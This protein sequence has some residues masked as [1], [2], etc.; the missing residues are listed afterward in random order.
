MPTDDRQESDEQNPDDYYN[1]PAN[2]EYA[3][4]ITIRDGRI[5]HIDGRPVTGNLKG[6]KVG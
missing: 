1:P 3:P 2:L 5:Y 6:S 4:E